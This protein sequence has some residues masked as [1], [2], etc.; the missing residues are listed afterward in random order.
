MRSGFWFS[1]KL[2]VDTFLLNVKD[3]PSIFYTGLLPF[4][5]DAPYS[6]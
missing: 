5:E 3:S 1:D 4:P 6:R 2:L